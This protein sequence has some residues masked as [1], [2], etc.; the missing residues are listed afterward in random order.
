[1]IYVVFG[2]GCVVGVVSCY[3]FMTIRFEK[4]KA[5]ARRYVEEMAKKGALK[6]DGNTVRKL[7]LN[8]DKKRG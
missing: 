1:M 2:C 4:R 5:L 6:V 8:V 7:H 3:V